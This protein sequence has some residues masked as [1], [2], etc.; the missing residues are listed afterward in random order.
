MIKRDSRLAAGGGKNG[1]HSYGRR[2]RRL[3]VL[4]ELEGE[5]SG[6]SSEEVIQRS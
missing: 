4:G 6:A 3:L 1:Q 2:K 5:G